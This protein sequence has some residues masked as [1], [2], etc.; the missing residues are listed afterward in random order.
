[1]VNAP[2]SAEAPSLDG[3]REKLG[4]AR[5]HL[6]DLSDLIK[7]L[8]ESP[9]ARVTSRVVNDGD[10][11]LVRVKLLKLPPPLM[12]LIGGD[13]IHNMRSALD[14]LAVQLVRLNDK[15]PHRGNQ[16]PIYDSRPTEKDKRKRFE[17]CIDGMSKNHK[18]DVKKLQP[19]ELRGTKEGLM[20]SRLGALDNLDK[21]QMLTPVLPSVD[22]NEGPVGFIDTNIPVDFEILGGP[23]D[24]NNEV[25][26][27]RFRRAEGVTG[28][29]HYKVLMHTLTEFALGVPDVPILMLEDIHHFVSGI[30]EGFGTEFS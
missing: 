13:A 24:E 29:L 10:W 27:A 4:R 1:M 15:K 7:E 8:G 20:L 30:V 19:F 16:F 18:E 2:Y 3:C 26:F 25:T 12:S 21:H 17:R 23:I 28:H 11:L 5:T 9:E 22:L 6:E 14:H